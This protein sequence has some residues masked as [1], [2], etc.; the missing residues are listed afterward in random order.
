MELKPM[1]TSPLTEPNP[2][3]M[4]EQM[5]RLDAMI[6]GDPR[7]LTRANRDEFVSYLRGLRDSWAKEAAAGKTRATRAPKWTG[8]LP[9]PEDLGL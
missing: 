6:S 9:T 3:S 7:A 4:D 2:A 1:P 5:R 8:P